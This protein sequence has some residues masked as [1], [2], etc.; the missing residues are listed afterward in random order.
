M[1]VTTLVPDVEYAEQ[2][3]QQNLATTLQQLSTGLRVNQPSDDPTASANMVISLTESANVDQYTTNVS[4]VTAQ[5][6]TADD[7]IASI[8]TQLNSAISLATSAPTE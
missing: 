6:Q 2:Q 8:I 4:A 7:A 1:R 3:S 5:L